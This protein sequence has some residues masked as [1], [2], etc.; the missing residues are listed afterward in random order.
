MCTNK[1]I[2]ISLIILDWVIKIAENYQHNKYDSLFFISNSKICGMN[3]GTN[4]DHSYSF[5]VFY[6][7]NSKTALYQT[8]NK[9][10]KTSKELNRRN[11]IS[12]HLP[13]PYYLT[14]PLSYLSIINFS[15]HSISCS[16][17]NVNYRKEKYQVD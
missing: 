3:E 12:M 14:L 8:Y 6:H 4:M 2:H 16:D 15:L 13:P 17:Q 11:N 7:I 5:N 1:I 9:L 10:Q